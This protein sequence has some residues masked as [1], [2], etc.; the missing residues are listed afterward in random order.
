MFHFR[1]K[2]KQFVRTP[3]PERSNGGQAIIEAVVALA[4]I[5][6]ILSAISVSVITSVNNTDFIK[7]QTLAKKSAEQA[8]EYIRYVRNNNPGCIGGTPGC[9]LVPRSFFSYASNSPYC[10]NEVDVENPDQDPFVP[11]SCGQTNI[12]DFKREVTFSHNDSQCGGG[13]SKVSVSVSWTS[14]KCSSGGFCHSSKLV[15][16]FPSIP[17]SL[18]T[19]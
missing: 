15:S 13:G 8:M 1:L 19:L 10:M 9:T 7:K 14:S 12:G 3:T 4:V 2:N 17:D 11:G 16:C 6:V 5:L 18:K